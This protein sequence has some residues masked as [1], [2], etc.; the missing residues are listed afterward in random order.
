MCTLLGTK[1]G[2]Y[3]PDNHKIVTVALRHMDKKSMMGKALQEMH[4]WSGGPVPGVGFCPV[5]AV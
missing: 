3:I 5:V 2:V 1:C 4:C